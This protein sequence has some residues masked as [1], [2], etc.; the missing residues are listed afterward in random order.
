MKTTS[1][2]IGLLLMLGSVILFL[3]SCAPV[4]SEMQSARMI[5]ENQFE[6]AGSFSS[7]SFADDGEQEP[8]QTN[9][10]LQVGYGISDKVDIRGRFEHIKVNDIDETVNV[11]GIGPKFSLVDRYMAFYIPVGNGLG[12]YNENWQVHPTLLFTLPLAKD[13]L[14]ITVAPKYLLTFCEGCDDGFALNTGIS[15]GELDRFAVRLEY[16]LLKNTAA[17]EEGQ[18]NH[19]SIGAAITLGKKAN[20]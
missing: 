17:F 11:I 15:V 6:L 10:G 12:D 4:F 3:P 9:T 7:V 5:G 14:E 16:G 13:I 20:R 8:V 2:P 1:S 19:I 18:Y